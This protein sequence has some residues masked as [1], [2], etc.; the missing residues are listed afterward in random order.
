MLSSQNPWND[1]QVTFE[2][3]LSLLT[4]LRENSNDMC[5]DTYKNSGAAARDSKA[6]Y[7]R[8][9]LVV[10]ARVKKIWLYSDFFSKEF[11]VIQIRNIRICALDR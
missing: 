1:T 2:V 11:R 3:V 5:S 6:K 9:Y 10:G 8:E 7:S 4:A